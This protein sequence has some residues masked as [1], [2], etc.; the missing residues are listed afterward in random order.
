[1]TPDFPPLRAARLERLFACLPR[2]GRDYADLRNHDLPG[3][4]HVSRLSPY[5]RHR[6]VTEEDILATVLARS[7]LPPSTSS[8]RM[9]SGAPIGKFGSRCGPRF[10]TAFFADSRQRRTATGPR[11]ACTTGGTPP[12]VAKPGSTGS[13]AGR[14]SLPALAICTITPG[15]GSPRSGSSPSASPGSL[16]RISSCA[17]CWMATPPRTRSRGV[18]SEA[19]RPSARPTSPGPTMWPATL[20]AVCGLAVRHPRHCPCRTRGQPRDA[21]LPP[22]THGLLLPALV[23]F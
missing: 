19:C 18:G 7:P 2:A 5:L 13:M 12:A 16:E 21:P 9:R 15:C 23:S 11:P 1:M 14:K 6:I 20:E 3:H 4:P 22:G 10:G 8:S 17:I